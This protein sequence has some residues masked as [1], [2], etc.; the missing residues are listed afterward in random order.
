ME[1]EKNKDK[2]IAIEMAQD[3]LIQV[4]GEAASQMIQAYKGVRYDAVG[5]DLNHKG[6]NLKVIKSYKIN[7]KYSKINIKQQAGFSAEL[8]QEAR[9]NKKYILS[10]KSERMRTT[11]G[12][13]MTND[14]KYDHVQVDG[15]GQI[16]GDS[17]TQ[18]KFYS[19]KSKN[20]K[21]VYCVIE[22][23]VKDDSWERYDKP[24]DIPKEQYY[25][26]K[27]YARKRAEKLQC[28][29]GKLRNKKLIS[30]AI[31]LEEKAR[32]YEQASERIRQSNV[33][34]N[35]AVMARLK[36]ESFVMKETI[37]DVH[38]AGSESAIGAMVLTSAMT[39][40]QNI[41]SIMAY[42]KDVKEAIDEIVKDTA[43]TGIINYCVGVTGTTLKAIMHS[44]NC[45]LIRRCGNTSLPTAIATS[46]IEVSKSLKR[47]ANSEINE[48]ELLVELGEKGTGMLAAGY[49][50]VI[51]GTIG[52][53]VGSIIPVLGTATG[54]M[55]GS[56]FGSLVGYTTSTVLY[57]GALETLKA[58]KMSEQKRSIIERFAYEAIE[59][60]N[61]YIEFLEKYLEESR[62][63]YREIICQILNLMQGSILDNKLETY[64][65][66][67]E[68]L[69]ICFGISLKYKT[70][71]EFDIAMSNN[72]K[73][74]L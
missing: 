73:I 55:I 63:N 21:D 47:Y 54:A 57:V 23:L 52:A 31:E 40:A 51:G 37:C 14:V 15:N 9:M 41:Y 58:E 62:E 66:L 22:K 17:G 49:G 33:S 56:F 64:V 7:P 5:N 1:K 43:N 30:K 29:A 3:S 44:S 26:A 39:S 18:M 34:T 2:D 60:N 45:E 46:V 35:E 24:I 74:V 27:E 25:Q 16:I 48:E 69:G 28:E 68:Q 10:G 6:R 11:D 61:Q 8:L 67:I 4:E 38:R 53:G 70:F 65:S 13:G 19:V 20:G 36:P 71:E 32:K 42:K 59:K 12:M 50:T 72:E